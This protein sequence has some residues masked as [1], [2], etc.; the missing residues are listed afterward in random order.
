MFDE[1]S[2]VLKNCEEY[3]EL[4][5]EREISSNEDKKGVIPKSRETHHDISRQGRIIKDHQKDQVVEDLQKGVI[6]RSSLYNACSNLASVS[7]I[8]SKP[9]KEDE[10]D[11][12]WV[13]ALLKEMKFI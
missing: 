2:A 12:S 1:Y 10:K 13:G 5:I 8:E 11:E 3:P 9:F 6:I 4:S 7:R